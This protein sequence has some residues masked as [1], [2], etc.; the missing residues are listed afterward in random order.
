[1]AMA[2]REV[3]KRTKQYYSQ[4]GSEVLCELSVGSSDYASNSPGTASPHGTSSR[5]FDIPLP[6]RRVGGGLHS[7]PN[8]PV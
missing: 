7:S 3:S 4:Y 1:M 2:T 6:S 8:W 5:I